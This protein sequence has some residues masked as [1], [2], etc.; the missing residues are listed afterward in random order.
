LGAALDDPD[1]GVRQD[2]AYA[3]GVVDPEAAQAAGLRKDADGN[4]VRL[5][6]VVHSSSTVTPTLDPVPT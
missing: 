2:A 5:R 6:V 3:L 1:A 4:M